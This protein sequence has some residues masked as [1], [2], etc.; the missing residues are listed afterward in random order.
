MKKRIFPLV[1]ALSLLLAVCANAATPRYAVTKSCT[2]S[3]TFSSQTATCKVTLT[4]SD[5]SASIDLT[6]TLSDS[7]GRALA[8]WPVTRTGTITQ[9]CPVTIGETYTLSIT[10]TVSG[11]NGTDNINVSKTSE[12]SG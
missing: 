4:T 11:A 1:L 3:L 2:P 10:G 9:T 6:M 12:C 8:S 5:R 7:S